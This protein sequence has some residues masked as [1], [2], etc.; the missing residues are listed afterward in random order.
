MPLRQRLVFVELLVP[1]IDALLVQTAAEFLANAEQLFLVRLLETQ[2]LLDEFR[3]E[4][5]LQPRKRL[6]AEAVLMEPR[7]PLRF[8]AIGDFRTGGAATRVPDRLD[9]VLF[10]QSEREVVV[11]SKKPDARGA[12]VD[13]RIIGF[14]QSSAVG[15]LGCYPGKILGL[16]LRRHRRSTQRK[17]L[18]V[19][20]LLDIF[21]ATD[22][23]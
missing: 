7:Q 13:G 17:T 1:P 2:S 9:V 16:P 20:E 3:I 21:R 10:F 5:P 22:A 8:G 12:A 11:F 19:P 4:V 18:V 6:H 15:E 23:Q 14:D